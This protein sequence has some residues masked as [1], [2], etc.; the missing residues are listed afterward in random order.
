M[1][2]SVKATTAYINLEGGFWGLKADENYLPIN[3]P[4]QLKTNGVPVICELEILED[5]VRFRNWG[6]L[7]RI[8]Q[9]QTLKPY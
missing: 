4:E 9:F 6:T 3:Y 5:A 1:I 2:R 7:C 8:T